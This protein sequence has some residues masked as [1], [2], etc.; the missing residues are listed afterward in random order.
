MEARHH[1]GGYCLGNPQVIKRK[2]N[3][4]A[5]KVYQVADWSPREQVRGRKREAAMN[6]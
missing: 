1:Q 3:E 6:G 2:V 5:A 4:V